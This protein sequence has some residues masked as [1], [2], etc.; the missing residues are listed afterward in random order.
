MFQIKMVTRIWSRF[1]Y[2]MMIINKNRDKLNSLNM[3]ISLKKY[4]KDFHRE[5]MNNQTHSQA[6]SQN[7]LKL[8][9]INFKAKFKN[10]KLK[11]NCKITN[12]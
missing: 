6:G 3:R 1:I 2:I 11:Y 9:P 10:L 4:K 8:N 7:Q 12:Q 5:I